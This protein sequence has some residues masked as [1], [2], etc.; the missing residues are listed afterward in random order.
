MDRWGTGILQEHWGWSAGGA[1]DHREE[2]TRRPGAT[3]TSTENHV[4][5]FFR[6]F[7]T[8]PM[9]CW[10]SFWLVR[11][12]DIRPLCLSLKTYSLWKA[13]EGLEKCSWRIWRFEEA[14]ED[15][16]RSSH[17]FLNLKTPSMPFNQGPFA[18]NR[19]CSIVGGD[20]ILELQHFHF[21]VLF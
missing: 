10:P 17:C 3:K 6:S 2:P 14:L 19:L 18:L 21:V 9:P 11:A 12:L 13:F 16:L 4:R 15:W 8:Y 7:S 1:R 5:G 20:F